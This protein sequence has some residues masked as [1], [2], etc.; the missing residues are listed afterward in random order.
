MYLPRN[1]CRIPSAAVAD[2]P[3]LEGAFL[4]ESAQE[5][6]ER[7]HSRVHLPVEARLSCQATNHFEEPAHLRDVSAGGAFLYADLELAPGMVVRL[8]FMV[9]VAGTRVQVSSEGSVVRVEPNALGERSGIAVEF[10]SLHL[11]S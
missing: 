1:V 8:D 3:R 7:R 10:A 6:R 4:M 9:P 5:A 11:G 2:S